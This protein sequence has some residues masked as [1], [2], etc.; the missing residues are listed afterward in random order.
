MNIIVQALG[1]FFSNLINNLLNALFMAFG[2][3]EMLIGNT[4]L[5]LTTGNPVVF[6]A[7]VTL[8]AIAD[9]F[10]GLYVI[11]KLIQMMHG[12][13]TGTA[14]MPIGQFVPKVI[15]TVILI[16]ASSFLGRELLFLVNA[17]CSIVL[18]NVQGFIMQINNGQLFG[19]GQTIGFG[20]VLGI[21]FGL[22]LFRLVF[23]AIKRIVLFNVLFVFS[24]PAF[25]MS[26]DAQTAPWFEFWMRLYVSNIFL[27]FFQFLAFGLGIQFLVATNQTGLTGFILAIAMLNLTVEI[28]SIV[29]A[30]IRFKRRQY[31]GA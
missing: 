19:T 21:V 20:T 31:Q 25:L 5:N 26:L 17:L 11:V 30:F 14:H 8:T 3:I 15:L 12:D 28:P 7:W 6:G 13:A 1:M 27:Q 23:Q 2:P 9:S 10:L 4:P 22:N 24:G 18:V 29:L 16:H